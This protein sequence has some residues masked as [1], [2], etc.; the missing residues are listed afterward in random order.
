MGYVLLL[1]AQQGWGVAAL[2]LPAYLLSELV[3]GFVRRIRLGAPWLPFTL[4]PCFR[5]ALAQGMRPDS[6]TREVIGI[7]IL[8]AALAVLGSLSP[9]L[10]WLHVVMAYG[11]AV[12]FQLSFLRG[13][14]A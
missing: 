2:I 11:V 14:K 4:K 6:L 7:H 5:H 1:L 10:G 12:A 9:E 8:I 13:G 3:V